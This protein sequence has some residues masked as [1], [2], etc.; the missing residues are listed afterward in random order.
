MFTI[1]KLDLTFQ[2]T[3]HCAKFHENQAKIADVGS[4]TDTQTQVML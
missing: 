1:Y 3:N 2:A 4:T